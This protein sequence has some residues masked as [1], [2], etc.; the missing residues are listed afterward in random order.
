MNDSRHEIELRGCAPVP[1]AHYLKALGILRLVAEQL[2]P[3]AQGWWDRDVFRLRSQLDEDGLVEFFLENYSPTPLVAPWNGGSGFFPKDNTAA[4]D[5][6]RD[7]SAERLTS[8]REAI[9]ASERVLKSL[10]LTAKPDEIS[11]ALLLQECR[12]RFPDEFLAWLD[13]AYVMT[14]D[15]AK[16]PPILGTGGN[17]GRL[18]FTNNFM[19]RLCELFDP[20]TGLPRA[21]NAYT[22]ESAL[23]GVVSNEQT[24]APIGQ[25]DP[26]SAGGPNATTGYEDAPRINLW[27]FVLALE[28]AIAFAASSVKKLESLKSGT[29]AYPF[30][31]R[32]VGAGYGSASASDESASRAEM[33]LPL[34]ERPSHFAAVSMLLSEGR[35]EVPGR[36]A[37]NGVDFARAISSLGI[38]RGISSFQRFAFQQRYGLSYL[39]VPLGRQPV[40]LVPGVHS[41]I[42]PLDPWLD[43]F[44]SAASKENAPAR[45]GRALRRLESAILDLCS[46]GRKEDAL[47]VLIALGEAES[48]VAVSPRLRE[49]VRSPLPLL[50]VDWLTQTYDRSPEFRL[51]ASLASLWHPS[52][53]PLRRHLEAVDPTSCAKGFPRWSRDGDDPAMVW[54][55]GNLVRNLNALLRRRIIDVLRL[56]GEKG[57]NELLAPLKGRC[58]AAPRDIADFIDGRVNDQRIEALLRGLMLL[59]WKSFKGEHRDLLRGPDH[60]LPDA[61]WALLKLCHLPFTLDDVPIRLTP[62][63]TMRATSGD[64]PGATRL[65]ARRLRSSGLPPAVEVVPVQRDRMR[66]IAAALVFPIE[67]FTAGRLR[68]FVQRRK[69]QDEDDTTPDTRPAEST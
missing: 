28:G 3:K 51:A 6:I 30:C 20:D 39:A 35:A 26:G 45:A 68:R 31:V 15:G 4:I 62:A 64:G 37:R 54:G 33:W 8:Y 65:A 23:F 42:A 34:W 22:L 10:S 32:T 60:P 17:D 19:Q 61:A 21:G 29:L 69:D 9:R 2:D 49:A 38:D 40:R 25:F 66:R 36:K 14:D 57:E 27:D 5:A 7:G 50:K 43:R 56:G 18:E 13:A 58:P 16:F 55:G 11:K 67:K 47:A 48:A 53:G 44:R 24:K 12:N 46:Y 59:D 1:L 52:L 41:L 63:I